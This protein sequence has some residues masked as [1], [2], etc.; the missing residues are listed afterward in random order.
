MTAL[1]PAP[2]A[3]VDAVAQNRRRRSSRRR[4]VVTVLAV[5]V[6]LLFIATLMIGRTSYPLGDVVRVV[7][8]ER[9]E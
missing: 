3:D 7:L 5:L 4:V 2:A 9:V 6:V 1:L 8:G